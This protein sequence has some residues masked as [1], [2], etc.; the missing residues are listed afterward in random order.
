MTRQ[1][2]VCLGVEDQL[3]EGVFVLLLGDRG[4][5]ELAGHHLCFQ[6][7]ALLQALHRQLCVKSKINKKRK[8]NLLACRRPTPDWF[9]ALEQVS[10]SQG[11]GVSVAIPR[12]ISSHLNWESRRTLQTGAMEA[13]RCRCFASSSLRCVAHAV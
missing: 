7:P 12:E 5:H 2:L 11:Q 6:Q 13:A 8:K 9:L 3:P 10:V 4:K 1:Q